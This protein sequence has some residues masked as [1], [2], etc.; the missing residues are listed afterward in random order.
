MTPEIIALYIQI[1]LV[2]V[3]VLTGWL[4][5]RALSTR[6]DKWRS[7]IAEQNKL[8]L[9]S[10]ERSAKLQLESNEKNAKVYARALDKLT[11]SHYELSEILI[12]HD[13][14]V[15]GVNPDV[16]G[17]TKEIMGREPKSD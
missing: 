17:T 9:E 8:Q 15:R 12:K 13:A 16:M 6:D 10:N 3:V 14:T 1:P 5:F 4:I 11:E 7:F 2:G